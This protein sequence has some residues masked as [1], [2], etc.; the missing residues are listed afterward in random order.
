LSH[1]VHME[2]FSSDLK[3][4]SQD[5]DNNVSKG[6]WTVSFKLEEF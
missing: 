3:K 1:I 2:D 4:H 5:I 6:I